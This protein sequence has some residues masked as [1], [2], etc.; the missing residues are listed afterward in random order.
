MKRAAIVRLWLGQFLSAVGSDL[1][2]VAF[3]WI[4]VEA[5][6]PNA[7][8]VAAIGLVSRLLFGPPGGIQADRLD[9]Q[10]LMIAADVGRS[11][12]VAT[13]AA[14]SVFAEIELWHLALVSVAI[15]AFDS[16]FDPALQGSLP[17]LLP[18]PRAA[19]RVNALLSVNHRLSRIVGPGLTGALL[20]IMPIAH[21]FAID[22]VSFVASAGL[23]ASLGRAHKWKPPRADGETPGL[24]REL[25]ATLRLVA[26]HRYLGFAL[27]LVSIWN[28]ASA[29]VI[30]VGLPL[31]AR[32]VLH[33]GPASYGYMIAAYGVGNVAS[34]LV[35]AA[36]PPRRQTRCLFS[37]GVIFGIAMIG[38]A[39][40]PSIEWAYAFAALA[41]IG[42]PRTDLVL[43]TVIQTHFAPD[44]IGKVFSLRLLASRVS[45]GVGLALAAGLY[46]LV[47]VRTGMAL[48]STAVA[49]Y[50]LALLAR[51]WNEPDGPL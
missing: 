41:A 48:A 3:M 10:K 34:N 30:S 17:A 29:A 44:Q 37:G 38:L 26:A 36:R 20:A 28:L 7:G 6:G 1:H 14:A 49:L 11:A 40:A 27:M 50:S 24:A 5:V 2:A 23:I 46:N 32:E 35:L 4:A 51:T 15:G 19:Q 8:L 21:F 25:A 39:Q 43:L 33:G 47:S 13:L 31:F 9:R 22:A 18:E 12:A 45:R 16:L 42:G